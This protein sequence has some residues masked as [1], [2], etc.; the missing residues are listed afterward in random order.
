MNIKV[1]NDKIIAGTFEFKAKDMNGI[2][3]NINY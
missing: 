2:I 3:G 1:F